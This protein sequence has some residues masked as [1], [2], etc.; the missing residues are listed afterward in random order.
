MA[1]YKMTLL[2]QYSST[3]Y[4]VNIGLKEMEGIKVS[5][6]NFRF[7]QEVMRYKII[8]SWLDCQNKNIFMSLC[9]KDLDWV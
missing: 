2:I 6:H 4:N 9:K 1:L 7:C 3:I 8:R 5:Q